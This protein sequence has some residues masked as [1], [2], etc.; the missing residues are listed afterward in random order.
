MWGEDT[1]SKAKAERRLIAL[2]TKQMAMAG[3]IN[4][5]DEGIIS[6]MVTWCE[7]VVS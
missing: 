4:P 3:T 6:D 7:P 5:P 2:G 1:I